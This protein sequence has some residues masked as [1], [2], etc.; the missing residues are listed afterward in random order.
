MKESYYKCHFVSDHKLV[1]ITNQLGIGKGKVKEV[2]FKIKVENIVKT[3][4]VPFQ[5]NIFC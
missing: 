1:I 5:V 4:D 2:D 3:L